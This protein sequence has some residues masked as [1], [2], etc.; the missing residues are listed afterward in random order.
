[1]LKTKINFSGDL[2]VALHEACYRDEGELSI[3]YM[4]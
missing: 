3:Q 1:V 4:D 2:H